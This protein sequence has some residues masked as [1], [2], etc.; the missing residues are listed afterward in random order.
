M[1]LVSAL[2]ALFSAGAAAQQSTYYELQKGDFPHDV[3]ASP[4]GEVWYAGQRAG[5][6]GRLDPATGHVERIPLGKDAAPQGVI[7][8]PDGIAAWFT[9]GG[10]NAIVRLDPRTKEIKIW[11]LPPERKDAELNTAAFDRLGRIWFTGQAG[12]YG[13]LNPTSGEIKV[14]DAPE[15]AGPYGM[16]ATPKGDIWFVSFAGSYL[17]NVDLESGAAT[18]FE[19]PAPGKVEPGAC[20]RIQEGTCG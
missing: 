10:R 3:A 9:D 16:T 18:V 14:W 8:G 12:I 2:L 13:R 20:G 1:I 5:V 15:G 17:A 11:P 7:V 19:P 6:A 4:S